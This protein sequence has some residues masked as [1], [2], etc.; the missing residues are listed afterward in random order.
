MIMA[1]FKDS[2]PEGIIGGDI[3]VTFVSKDSRFDL[4]VSETGAE[5]KGNILVHRLKRLQ[6]EGVTGRSRFYA[7][8]KGGVNEVD[9]KRWGEQCDIDIV[10]VV[11]G[12][13][14]GTAREG[15]RA[16]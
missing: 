13:K 8:E 3:D 12:E 6:D 9:K 16:S 11:R 1:S 7:L 2:A 15:V 10:S 14:V 5:R 4:P